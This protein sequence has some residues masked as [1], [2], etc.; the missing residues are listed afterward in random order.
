MGPVDFWAGV[1]NGLGVDF[2]VFQG[3]GRRRTATVEEEIVDVTDIVGAA[4]A[5]DEEI[6]DVTGMMTSAEVDVSAR[7]ASSEA[8]LTA[9]ADAG[10]TAETKPAP[11]PDAGDAA[12]LVR[13]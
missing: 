1:F 9:R 8:E 3:L 4:S 12:V 6:V 13:N 2:S 10:A 5:E 11:A 7:L